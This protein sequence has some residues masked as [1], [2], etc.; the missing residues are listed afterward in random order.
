MTIPTGGIPTT[1]P[2]MPHTGPVDR[3]E[4]GVRVAGWLTNENREGWGAWIR[5]GIFDLHLDLLNVD[6]SRVETQA[7]LARRVFIPR[8]RK[9][10]PLS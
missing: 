8:Q 4:L 1:A 2:R 6:T 3:L 10:S 9:A 5:P 7:D